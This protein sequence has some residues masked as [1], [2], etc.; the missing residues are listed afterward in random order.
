MDVQQFLEQAVHITSSLSRLH[1]SG[2][3]HLDIRPANI[4]MNP[5]TGESALQ[6]G[7]SAAALTREIEALRGDGTRL[8]RMAAAAVARARPHAA[9]EIARRVLALA[10]PP[11]VASV[12]QRAL[13]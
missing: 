4:V 8:A 2:A 9:E 12:P 6:G 11:G 10:S 13:S 7:L 5:V 3:L 1:K